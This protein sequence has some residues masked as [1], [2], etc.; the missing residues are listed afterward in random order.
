M[1]CIKINHVAY[2]EKG[3]IAHGENLQNV[4]E[5]ANTTNQE[6]VI[7][8]VPSCRYSIQILPIQV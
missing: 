6:F 4:L 8:L 1:I 2:N 5:E 7:Y 3:V